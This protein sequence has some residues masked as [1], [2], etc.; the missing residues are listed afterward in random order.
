MQS[1]TAVLVHLFNTNRKGCRMLSRFFLHP[2]LISEMV[3]MDVSVLSCSVLVIP[4]CDDE[5]PVSVPT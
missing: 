4:K 1:S 3:S 2:C 5:T